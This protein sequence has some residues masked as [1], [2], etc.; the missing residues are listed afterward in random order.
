[1]RSSI[2]ID[3]R[4]GDELTPEEQVA[5]NGNNSATTTPVLLSRADHP[6]TGQ[7]CW[8][9]HPCDT[10]AM[11]NEILEASQAE[12]A[13]AAPAES[14]PRESPTLDWALEWLEAWL[15]V[16]GGIVDLQP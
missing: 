6:A 13:A 12:A 10:E 5:A 1:M 14:E 7:F 2:F 4:L 8:F 3:G 9:L 16:I 11:V 15:M